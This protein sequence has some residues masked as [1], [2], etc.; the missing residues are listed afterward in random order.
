[1]DFTNHSSCHSCKT[2]APGEDTCPGV[3]AP[4]GGR[5]ILT[6][7]G[8]LLLPLLLAIT[9]AAAAGRT[10]KAH[11]V[12]GLAGLGLGLV[13]AAVVVRLLGHRRE[14]TKPA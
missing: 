9:G 6:A 14:G 12:G 5:L 10:E 11:I 2:C 13:G 3:D 8:S 1:M 4:S 7:V